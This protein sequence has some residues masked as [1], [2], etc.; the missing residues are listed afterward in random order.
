MSTVSANNTLP[1]PANEAP[2]AASPAK[3]PFFS[4]GNRYLAPLLITII[5]LVGQLAYGFLESYTRTAL[6]VGTGPG[7]EERRAIAIVVIGG[8][9]LSLFLTLIVT[10][11]AFYLVENV[12]TRTVARRSAAAATAA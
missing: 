7:A 5:L 12:R 8:Q 10:P 6:A 4:L 2:V 1:V 3:T 11:V 9:S